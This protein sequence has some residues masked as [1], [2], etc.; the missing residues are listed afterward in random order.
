M[1]HMQNEGAVCT[2]ERCSRTISLQLDHTESSL[3]AKWPE[4][5]GCAEGTT[6]VIGVQEGAIQ[7][8]QAHS[9][10]TA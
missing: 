3:R 6:A 9:V 5:C 8:H 4:L 1:R 10:R 2:I 7:G